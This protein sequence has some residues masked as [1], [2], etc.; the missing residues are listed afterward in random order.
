MFFFD[1]EPVSSYKIY[2]AIVSQAGT[3][4]PVANVLE[5]T[6]G[7]TP[8]WTRFSQGI[9]YCTLAGAFPD[10][11]KVFFSSSSATNAPFYISM[12]TSVPDKIIVVT[13]RAGL[14]DSILTFS[15]IEI[16]VYP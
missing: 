1:L 15:S 12:N 7:G 3:S 8:V 9:Y 10:L 6:L 13:E 16:I 11:S 14:S 4:D 2:R 5:N